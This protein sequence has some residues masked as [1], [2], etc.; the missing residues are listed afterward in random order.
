[1]LEIIVSKSSKEAWKNLWDYLTKNGIEYEIKEDFRL[2]WR[3]IGKNIE[4]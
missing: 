3:F 2:M 1:M 4:K